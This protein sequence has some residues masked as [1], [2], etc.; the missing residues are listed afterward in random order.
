MFGIIYFGTEARKLLL[1]EI[2]S[3]PS[4]KVGVLLTTALQELDKALNT[5]SEQVEEDVSQVHNSRMVSCF[6]V[7]QLF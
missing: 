7:L 3:K 2:Q 1:L 6:S 4:D 5:I